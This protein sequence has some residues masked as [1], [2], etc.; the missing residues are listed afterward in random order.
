MT[1][2]AGRW[3]AAKPASNASLSIVSA[4]FETR[5]QG[6]LEFYVVLEMNE[7]GEEGRLSGSLFTINA[8]GGDEVVYANRIV[9]D[10]TLDKRANGC[11]SVLLV[12]TGTGLAPFVSM[13]RQRHFDASH[14]AA[15]RL[16]VVF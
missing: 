15:D 13:I 10:F 6:H 5:E 12:G 1:A 14:G 7:R 3:S 2:A 8:G 4:P 9:G 11:T 16:Q